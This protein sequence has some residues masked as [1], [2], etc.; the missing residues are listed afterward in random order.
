MTR[1]VL[2]GGRYLQTFKN[3]R[4]LNYV[5]GR[6]ELESY[7]RP[8]LLLGLQLETVTS[9]DMST[10]PQTHSLQAFYKFTHQPG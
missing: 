1:C 6:N 10:T 8:L 2:H 9:M 7:G 5:I 4:R 3:I